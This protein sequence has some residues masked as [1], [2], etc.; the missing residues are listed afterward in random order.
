M[1][2]V[3]YI[4]FANEE[5]ATGGG[6]CAGRNLESIQ[7]LLGKENVVDYILSP[8]KDR[9][10]IERLSRFVG[11]IKGYMGGLTDEHVANIMKMIDEW[12]YYIST[13]RK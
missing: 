1:R 5:S 9:S 12:H 6:Q 4:T 11:V 8:K 3:L 13:K 2:K 10:L 7:C